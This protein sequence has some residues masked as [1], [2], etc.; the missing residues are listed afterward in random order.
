MLSVVWLVRVRMLEDKS[1]FVRVKVPNTKK[2]EEHS[3]RPVA[4]AVHAKTQRVVRHEDSE[5]N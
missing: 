3:A 1:C 5:G 4:I 2:E